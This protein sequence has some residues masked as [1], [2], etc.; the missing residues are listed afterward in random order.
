MS[1]LVR[2]TGA[3]L[4]ALAR[5]R[6]PAVLDPAALRPGDPPPTDG[7]L[8]LLFDGACGICL[9]VRDLFA[10][11]DRRDRLRYD[12]IARHDDGLLAAIPVAQRYD[13]WHVIH[14]DGTA[15]DGAAGLASVLAAL[16]GGR[17][18]AAVIRRTPTFSERAYRW[19]AANRGWISRGAG[20]TGHPQRDPDELPPTTRPPRP[21]DRSVRA[22]D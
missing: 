17:L 11:L 13:S 9:H 21:S 8:L 2:L 5:E 14:P 10:A 1:G 6:P 3:P 7:R 15:E 19:F 4:R 20:L 22:A 16:P 12:R 18:P